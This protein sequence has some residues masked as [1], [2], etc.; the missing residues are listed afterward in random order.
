M[1]T[2]PVPRAKRRP[3]ASPGWVPLEVVLKFK[4]GREFAL[5]VD[6]LAAELR[7]TKS[8]VLRESVRRGLPALINDVRI[9]RQEGYTNPA[10]VAG[11]LALS[12]RRGDKGEGPVSARWLKTP[13]DVPT[14]PVVPAPEMDPD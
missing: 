7:L 8:A 14:E 4:V 1:S 2:T 5:A 6:Q 11:R 9:L 13:G 10:H 12:G 3:P